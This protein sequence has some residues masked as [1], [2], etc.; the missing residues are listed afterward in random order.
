MMLSKR[1]FEGRAMESLLSWQDCRIQDWENLVGLQLCP[2][3][4][5]WSS[6]HGQAS[7]CL[8]SSVSSVGRW[9]VT[10][11]I[12]VSLQNSYVEALTSKVPV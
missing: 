12:L 7:F 1:I 6:P 2:S 4:G 10:D 11:R 8:S 5:T 3:A 9:G